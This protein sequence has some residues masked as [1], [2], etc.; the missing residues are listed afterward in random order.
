MLY[1]DL[2]IGESTESRLDNYLEECKVK[3]LKGPLIS[4]SFPHK[5]R[6]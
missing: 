4:P 3:V 1:V 6:Q 2:K 5:G